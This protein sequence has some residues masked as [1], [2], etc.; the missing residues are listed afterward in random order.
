MKKFYFLLTFALGV[1][2]SCGT[3]QYQSSSSNKSNNI[4]SF[5]KSSWAVLPAINGYVVNEFTNTLNERFDKLM[6]KKENS[7]IVKTPKDFHKSLKDKK[8]RE[9]YARIALKIYQNDK[10]DHSKV[11]YGTGL[12]TKVKS[13][14]EYEADVDPLVTLAGIEAKTI[15]KIKKDVKVLKK[16]LKTDFALIPV[17]SAYNPMYTRS[18][19]WVTFFPVFL[20]KKVKENFFIN[21]YLLDLKSGKNVLMIK[22]TGSDAGIVRTTQIDYILTKVLFIKI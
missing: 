10:H 2:I 5:Q 15:K 11:E 17:V 3:V 7:F 12:R 14:S 9:A 21:F 19:I 4:Q 16:Y 22:G 18:Q 8:F 6:E 20:S 1:V 13:A